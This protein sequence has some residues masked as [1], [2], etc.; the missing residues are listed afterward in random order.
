MFDS[1]QKRKKSQIEVEL[2]LDDGSHYLGKFGLGMSERLSD[3][4]NDERN[5]L[6]FETSDG[7]VVV[8]RKTT[9]SKVVQ[10]DQRVDPEK[11][12]NPYAILGVEH[13]VSDEE[14]NQAY[15]QLCAANHPDKMQS[16][17]MAADFVDIA[18]SRMARINDAY[19]RIRSMRNGFQPQ[20]GADGAEARAAH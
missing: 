20:G 5:F 14:L 11:V 19:G 17:G 13:D 10:L 18:N 2:H 3:M 8:I 1:S 6:P 16:S 7:H 15:R 12:S 9:I 4:M